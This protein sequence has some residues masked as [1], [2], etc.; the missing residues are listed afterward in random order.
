MKKMSE[1]VL[2]RSNMRMCVVETCNIEMQSRPMQSRSLLGVGIRL[3][4]T[5]QFSFLVFRKIQLD[6]NRNR[7]VTL[8]TQ[9][10]VFRIRV[11]RFGLR[12]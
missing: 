7:S 12:S 6:E 9:D 11:F 3:D 4:R 1:N 5:N 2:L 8:K 10:L